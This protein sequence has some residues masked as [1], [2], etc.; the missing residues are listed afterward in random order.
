[1]NEY[2][3]DKIRNVVLIGHSSS[4]KTTLAEALLFDTGATNRLG[5][6]EESNTVSDYDPEEQRRKISISASLVPCEWNGYKIN[7]LDT[8]GYV[9]FVGEVKGALRV[10]DCAVI[11]VDAVSGIEVGTELVWQYC[12]EL[13][14]PRII[15][16][17]KM[18][19][20]NANF[21]RVLDQLRERFGK[22]V[23]AMQIPIGSQADFKGEVNVISGKAFLGHDDKP[24]DVPANLAGTVGERRSQLVEIAAES[25]DQL[26]EKYLAGEELTEE[27]IRKGLDAGIRNGSLVPVLCGAASANI[28]VP[29]LLKFFVD[30]CPAPTDM[31]VTV[32][33]NPATHKQ[34]KLP[35][36]DSGPLA[37]FVFK[38]QADPYVG[39]LTS[40]RVYSGAMTSDSRVVNSRTGDEERIGQLYILRGKEQIPIKRVSAG[41][42][43]AVA[44]LSETQ[45]GDTLGDKG[46]SLTLAKIAYPNPVY[47]VALNPKTKTDLDKMGS[48]LTRLVDEDPTLRVY[49]EPD[50]GETIMS[51]MGDSHVDV[52]TRRL[53]QKFGVELLTSVPKIPYKETITKKVEVQGRHKK[54]TGGRGQFG[55]TWVRFEPLPRGTGFEFAEEVF[56]GSVP[57]Q[58]I[59]AVEKGMREIIHKG[60]LAGFPATDFRAILYDGSYHAVDSSEM[61]FKLAAHKAFKNGFPQASPVLLEPVMKIE[62]TVPENFMG[63]VI[64]DLNTKRARVLG[65]DQRTGWSVVSAEAPLA[66]IERYATDLRSMT[67]GRGYFKMEFTR[68]DIVPSHIASQIIDKA[69]KERAGEE[70]EEEE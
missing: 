34:E 4:G 51:G 9:D 62:I 49:R 64:G 16:I 22:S 66:E 67:Q 43:G 41:D 44:K 31:P 17:N 28:G 24:S 48:A 45:T 10:A 53:K 26:I 60:V 21:D 47:S 40:F 25:D 32:A 1:M 18:D 57:H 56:G 23:V 63:D 65:M 12:D 70:V 42:I 33:E 38:T 59:P 15:Y 7:V 27:E 55:D 36:T 14:L 11:L 68:Y 3:T 39:K 13:N 30:Y 61:A 20:E 5:K 19:R 54:Q 58:F 8:P 37:T 52:A 50:T 2:S 69:R 46:H 35:V 29:Y 6:I